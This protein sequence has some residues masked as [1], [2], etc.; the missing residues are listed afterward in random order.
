MS[1]ATSSNLAPTAPTRGSSD[2]LALRMFGSRFRWIT[3]VGLQGFL[4]LFFLLTPH[5]TVWALSVTDTVETRVLFALYGGLLLHRAA[6]EQIVRKR[7]DPSWIRSY[8]ISTYPFGV[9]S[10]VILAWASIEG[11][12]NPIIGWI[13]VAL[14]VAEL[15]EYAVVL[16]RHRAERRADG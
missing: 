16:L 5:W 15:V 1:T 13:W 10:T 9:S 7:R 3:T 6:M 4:G 14:F 8:M 12:M 2:D 11:L